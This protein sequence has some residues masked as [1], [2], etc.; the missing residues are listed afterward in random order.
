MSPAQFVV[1]TGIAAL[2]SLLTAVFTGLGLF[3]FNLSWI[4]MSWHVA[5][6][7]STLVFG[8][9]HAALVMFFY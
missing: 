5:A 4:K 8:L 9:I 1:P 7:V 2:A 3:K 6:G